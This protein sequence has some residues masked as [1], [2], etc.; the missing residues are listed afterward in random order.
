MKFIS[1]LL[2]LISLNISAVEIT[3]SVRR[4]Y[5]QSGRVYFK[6]NETSENKCHN[7]SIYSYYFEIDRNA[8]LTDPKYHEKT[9][10]SQIYFQFMMQSAATKNTATPIEV[11]IDISQADFNSNCGITQI[12]VNYVKIY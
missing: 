6:L 2:F 1:I 11:T 10:L 8:L 7:N 12:P 3:G 9:T 5:P 4:I